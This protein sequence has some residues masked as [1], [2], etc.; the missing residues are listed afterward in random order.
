MRILQLVTR[1]QY[2]GAEVFA[3][4][5]STGLAERGHEVAFVGLYPAPETELTAPGC[6]NQDLGGNAG[7]KFSPKLLRTLVRYY[8]DYRPDIIQANGS[9]TLKYSVALK[10]LRPSARVVYRNISIISQWIRSSL[11]LRLQRWM[12]GRIDYVTSVSDE[13]RQDFVRTLQ[14]PEDRI[15][16]VRRGIDTEARLDR[17]AERERLG[18]DYPVVALVGKLS[19][20]KNHRF[21]IDCVQRL[22]DRL[23]TLHLWFVGDGPM[24]EELETYAQASGLKDRIRFWGVHSEI[25]PFLAA[26]DALAIVSTVEGIPG[27]I[28]EGAI[29]GTP[30]VAVDVGGVKEVLKDDVTGLLVPS[31]DLEAYAGA[32]ASI[33]ENDDLRRRLGEQARQNVRRDYAIDRAVTTFEQIYG[34]VLHQRP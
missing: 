9:D 18:V 10:L 12:F 34:D 13:S 21:L 27:V 30:T 16:T 1:R 11:Q 31:H 8:D 20:E 23:P 29:Q 19:V 24:R 14:Y 25:A 6:S 5:L 32:L 22:G 17:R 2:R 28:L 7:A 3:S 26:A 15:A 4:L 33:L